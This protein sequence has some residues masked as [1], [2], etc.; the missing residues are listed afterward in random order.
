MNRRKF[1]LIWTGG[2]VA[3]L[4]TPLMLLPE[5]YVCSCGR[6]TY[7]RRLEGHFAATHFDGQRFT[8]RLFRLHHHLHLKME[9]EKMKEL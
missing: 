4:T 2:V 5:S 3:T 9:A 1:I 7:F 8:Y 6:V